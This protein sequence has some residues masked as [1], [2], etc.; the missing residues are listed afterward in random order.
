MYRP[1]DWLIY[2]MQM[3]QVPEVT[4][5]ES[6]CTTIYKI[7]GSRPFNCSRAW[8]AEAFR[9]ITLRLLK[10]QSCTCFTSVQT[11]HIKVSAY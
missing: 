5:V 4:K 11:I 1:A 6:D 7:E 9:C 2:R 10:F 3:H 8:C